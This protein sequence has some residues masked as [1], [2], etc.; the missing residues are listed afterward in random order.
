[1]KD[2]APVLHKDMFT[3]GMNPTPTKASN[4]AK[5]VTFAKGDIEAGFKDAEVIV[6]GYYT[7]QPVHQAYIEP[8]ACLCSY[9]ADGQVTIYSSSQGHFM[10]RAYCAKLLGLDISNIRAV[11]L[12]IG[13]GFGGK[14]IAY[15]EPVA[16]ILSKKSGAPT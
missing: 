12:E 16:A 8:H 5:V 10:V 6:E 14:T 3:Q 9:N 7:T 4:I 2:D 11:P 13:G 15:L 1:M